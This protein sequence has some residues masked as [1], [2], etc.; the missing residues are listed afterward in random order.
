M[1]VYESFTEGLDDPDLVQAREAL[2]ALDPA[3]LGGGPQPPP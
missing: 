1:G 2:T 3:V